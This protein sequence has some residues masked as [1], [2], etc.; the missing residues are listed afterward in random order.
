MKEILL[1]FIAMMSLTNFMLLLE[2]VHRLAHR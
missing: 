1:G 2:V